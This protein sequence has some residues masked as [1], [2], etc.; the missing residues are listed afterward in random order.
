MIYIIDDDKSVRRSFELL[1]NSAGLNCQ[2]YSSAKEFLEEYCLTEGDLLILDI[3]MPDMDGCELLNLLKNKSIH[4]PVIVVTA[5][6]E[7]KSRQVAKN[8]GVIGYLLKPVN[9][10]ELIELI[11]NVIHSS[12]KHHSE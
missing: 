9:G 8:Y 7:E 11:G 6:D 3:H 2:S 1:L 4:V 12:V 10:D 5:Y